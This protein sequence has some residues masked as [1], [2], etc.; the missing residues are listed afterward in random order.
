ME[1]KWSHR[2][3]V[4]T[5]VTA[6]LYDFIYFPFLVILPSQISTL[7][8]SLSLA[9]ID[10]CH[11]KSVKPQQKER[12]RRRFFTSSILYS[13]SNQS[14]QIASTSE[15]PLQKAEWGSWQRE[16][17]KQPHLKV[18]SSPATWGSVVK[19]NQFWVQNY[20]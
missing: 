2:Y 19:C 14:S 17:L 13:A 18:L 6:N 8:L 9:C 5:K 4:R 10:F 12:K 16:R 7:M 3:P 11:I 15:A 1:A 20:L